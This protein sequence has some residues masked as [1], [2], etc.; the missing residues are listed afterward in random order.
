[1]RFSKGSQ[2]WAQGSQYK[3]AVKLL[4][5]IP[6]NIYLHCRQITDKLKSLAIIYTWA[7]NDQDLLKLPSGQFWKGNKDFRWFRW[8]LGSCLWMSFW[9]KIALGVFLLWLIRGFFCFVFLKA[10]GTSDKFLSAEFQPWVCF[11]F[12]L[13]FLWEPQSSLQ[14]ALALGHACGV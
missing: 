11:S 3:A 6:L 5:E 9:E 4:L 10:L 2:H 14:T 12:V 1:M 13:L 8:G 7:L